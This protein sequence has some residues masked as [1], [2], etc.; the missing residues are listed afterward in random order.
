MRVLGPLALGVGVLAFSLS[1]CGNTPSKAEKKGMPVMTQVVAI[2]PEALSTTLTG[3]VK[4]F[5]PSDLA[6]RLAGR[7]EARNVEVGDHV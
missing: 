6:F 1:G 5:L 2:A 7:I 4:A 3:E